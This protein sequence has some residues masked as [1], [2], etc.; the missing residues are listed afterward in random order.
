MKKAV[1]KKDYC[2]KVA[3]EVKNYITP[4]TISIFVKPSY[5]SKIKNSLKVKK[6][7]ILFEDSN[8]RSIYSPV[9]GK[10]IAHQEAIN[11]FNQT[12]KTITIKNDFK[13][14]LFKE[15]KPNIKTKKELLERLDA[16]KLSSYNS[17]SN[18]LY[19]FLNNLNKDDILVINC[20]DDE[21]YI[22]NKCM[23]LQKELGDILKTLDEIIKMF[24][25]KQIYILIEN[26]QSETINKVLKRIGTFI[27]ISVKLLP[28]YYGYGNNEVLENNI[29]ENNI[30]FLNVGDIIILHNILKKNKI[31]TKKY[32]TISGDK[33]ENPIVVKVKLG[34]SV[35]D[36]I[37][38]YIKIIE[39]DVEYF[40][41]G[42]INGYEISDINQLVVT[43][44]LEG[45]IITKVPDYKPS[46]CLN[47]GLCYL[48][49]P[50][51][52]DPRNSSHNDKCIHCN[53]CNY[54]CPAHIRLK[55]GKNESSV[56][57]NRK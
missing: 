23:I 30:N 13:E 52:I 22:A 40:A 10:I 49:C 4:E 53:L 57:E 31:T 35:K 37:K 42:L 1:V 20:I 27:N 47:C 39:E 2:I 28:N 46:E 55:E 18:D 21:P 9:S 25:L 6:E 36:L 33:I 50:I 19:S 7:Q 34:S 14:E 32:I 56:Y 44:D 3:S 15:N 26:T 51:N 29:T 45:I 41:N 48:N 24:S 8:H 54:I 38:K 11:C 5:S 43:N 16:L 12:L 17:S